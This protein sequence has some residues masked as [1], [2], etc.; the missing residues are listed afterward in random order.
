M[1]LEPPKKIKRIEN[2]AV[3]DIESANWTDFLCLGFFDGENYEEFFDLESF[4]K[5]LY[6]QKVDTIFAHFGGIFD[7]LFILQEI[8]EQ[9]HE[10][11]FK[12]IIPRGSGILQ[13]ELARRGFKRKIVFRDSSAL[14]PFSLK[15]ITE[16]FGVAHAKKDFDVAKIT[17]VTPELLEYLRYDCIGLWESLNKFFNSQILSDTS[18]R[19]TVA[20]Q[21]LEKFKNYLQNPLP[22][23]PKHADEFVRE[24]YA[25]GRVEIFNPVYTYRGKSL[26]CYDINSM[27]P[28][29]MLQDMPTQFEEFS[30]KMDLERMGFIHCEVCVPAEIKIPILWVKGKKFL[31]PVGNLKGIWSTLELRAAIKQ[32]AVINRV[33]ACAYFSNGG[34]IFK[35]FVTDLYEHRKNS[36][37]E[38][39]KIIAKLLMNSVYGKMGINL[40]REGLELD[41]GQVGVIPQ[42]EIKTRNGNIFRF[43]KTQV[44]L[45]SFSNVAIASW[46]TSIARTHLHSIL[47]QNANSLFYCDT[48]SIFTTNTLPTGSGLGKLKLEFETRDPCC[49]LLPKTYFTPHKISMKGFDKKKIAKFTF[50][51]FM[52]CL[53]GE[54]RLTQTSEVKMAR[55]KSAMKSGNFLF[56]KLESGKTIKS[57]YDKRILTKDSSGNWESVPIQI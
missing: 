54:I 52:A 12:K 26:K 48:D 53:E 50:E 47:E 22:A 33:L 39:E 4:L 1:F 24:S 46:I 56:K 20:S 34:P 30:P 10:F 9:S 14:L 31:F 45:R 18:H 36:E 40:D 15:K 6:V 35:E 51:D 42:F 17:E 25:G 44:S 32:G 19:F 38:V 57:K 5:F 43:V 8:L 11:S 29:A 28:F 7:F 27:Y 37:T 55:Y 41:N 21:A 23:C 3:F 2:F 16:T 13:F 49:F